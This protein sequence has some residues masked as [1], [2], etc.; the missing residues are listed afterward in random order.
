MS[1]VNSR[2]NS[3]WG[4]HEKQL[5]AQQNRDAKQVLAEQEEG[6]GSTFWLAW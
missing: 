4:T 3:N 6:E 1:D 2:I 5:F